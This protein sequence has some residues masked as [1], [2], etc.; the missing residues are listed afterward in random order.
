MEVLPINL[1]SFI[2]KAEKEKDHIPWLWA[3][4]V[5]GQSRVWMLMTCTS[6]LNMVAFILTPW[7]LFNL[8]WPFNARVLRWL[9]RLEV[10][11]FQCLLEFP[12]LPEC[13]ILDTWLRCLGPSRPA[14]CPCSFP[15]W[16]TWAW[17]SSHCT[18]LLEPV[19]VPPTG[20]LPT[21]FWLPKGTQDGVQPVRNFS[22]NHFWVAHC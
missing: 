1:L 15:S 9:P 8:T 2:Q 6:S 14:T 18:W 7:M 21:F 3:V 4:T 10:L 20:R 5:P 19:S 22:K 13:V 12:H 17:T 11:M 16:T